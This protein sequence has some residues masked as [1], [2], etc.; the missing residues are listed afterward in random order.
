LIAF[1][2]YL[3]TLFG[4]VT[5]TAE[6]TKNNACRRRRRHNVI[7]TAAEPA[8]RKEGLFLCRLLFMFDLTL[9]L[10]PARS[11]ACADCSY[12]QRE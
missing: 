4:C 3:E 8:G 1:V 9:Q 12:Q 5:D 10:L 11:L 2:L 7:V 6:L